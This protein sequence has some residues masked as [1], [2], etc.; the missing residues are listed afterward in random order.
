MP[1]YS[2]RILITGGSG[3][4][5]LNAL[6]NLIS[7][8]PDTDIIYSYAKDPNEAKYQLL[9]NKRKGTDAF[10]TPIFLRLIEI[11]LKFNTRFS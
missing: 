11:S 3:S 6:F 2:Y 5:K 10:N 8:Q 1:D 7:H 4:G 9:I